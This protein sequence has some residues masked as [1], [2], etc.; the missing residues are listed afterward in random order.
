M[1]SHQP[2]KHSPLPK[3]HPL[4]LG[5]SWRCHENMDAEFH[6]E[7]AAIPHTSY[8]VS[9]LERPTELIKQTNNQ[10]GLSLHHRP[11]L[12]KLPSPSPFGPLPTHE[13]HGLR[14]WQPMLLCV[15]SFS[16]LLNKLYHSVHTIC[17]NTYNVFVQKDPELKK[18]KADTPSSKSKRAVAFSIS[19]YNFEN[20]QKFTDAPCSL[21]SSRN[22][23]LQN[24]A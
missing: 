16:H 13:R 1:G 19:Y 11:Q 8:M 10:K 9:G 6:V 20:K 3:M 18:K 14:V 24:M 15:C 2:P 5:P 21:N 23:F 7:P 17:V 4:H 22:H 12:E